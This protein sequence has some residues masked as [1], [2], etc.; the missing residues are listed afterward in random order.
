MEAATIVYNNKQEFGGVSMAARQVFSGAGKSARSAGR[1]AATFTLSLLASAIALAQQAPAG[2]EEVSVTGSRLRNDSFTAPTPVMTL[3][4][5]QLAAVAPVNIAEALQQLPQFSTGGQ[6]STAVVYANLR[7]IGSE[8]TLVLLNGRRHVPTFSSGV[9][10]LTT[11]PTALVARTEMVTGGASASWGSDAV[12]GVLN[13]IVNED[14]EGFQGNAQY[15]ES[16][17]GDD[18]SYS[19]SLAW[20]TDFAGG[21]GHII[22]GV[23]QAESKGIATY[24]YPDVS[25]PNVAGRSSV[26][27]G[28]YTTGLPQFIYAEDVRRSDVHDGGLITSGPLRGTIFLPGGQTGQFQYGTN[29]NN[30]MIG[31]GSN[32]YETP[33]P[34]GDIAPPYERKSF[35]THAKYD[36]SETLSGFLEYNYSESL[37]NGRSVMPRNQGATTANTGC[38]RTSYSGSFFG[39]INVSSDNAFLPQAVR[40]QMAAARINCFNFGRTY[41]E[42]GLGLFRTG[43]GSPEIHRYVAGLE[44]EIGGGWSWDT[45]VQYGDSSFQ[46]RREGNIHS[47]RFQAAIDAV[48][49]PATGSTVC[50]I[51]IDTNPNN[52]DPACAPFNLFGAGS[53]SDAAK[54]YVVGTS[55]LD[56]D[57]EQTVAA[58]N[59]RGDLF[60]GWAGPISSAFGVEYREESLNAVADP[61]SEAGRWQTSNRKALKGSYD[62]KEVYAE[63]GVP[64]LSGAPLADSVDLSLAARST[65]YSSS[66][67]VTTWK[68]GLTWD[69]NE[70]L[71]FRVTKS[72]DIRAGNLGELF[73]PTAVALGNINNPRTS[74]RVPVQTITTG[75]PVLAPEEADT[76]TAGVVLAPA[77]IEGLQL[78]LDYYSIDIDG[79]I[80]TVSAQQI[81]DQCYLFNEQDFCARVT[82]DG[83]GLITAINNSFFNLDR[84]K[85]SGVDAVAAYS[86]DIGPG[87]MSFR[88][89]SAY[90]DERETTF[91]VAGTVQDTA[92]QVG[93]PHWKHFTQVGYRVG[94]FSGLIDWRWY[95]GG[96]IS[97]LRIEGFAGVQGANVNEIPNLHYTSLSLNY[98]FSGLL[99]G[100]NGTVFGRIDNLFDRD[101]PFPLRNA[102]NDNN[103]RGYRVGVRFNM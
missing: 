46:Q 17:Y 96:K 20:G 28:N 58:V 100:W 64:L 76:F 98:D 34:G 19:T 2:I 27:N 26:S 72:K 88:L 4:T 74:I 45:Y 77:A 21:R 81:V 71:R 8:R 22:A 68:T 52:N 67:E 97:N 9:V 102:Y 24:L 79:Q 93:T 41:R 66:G 16:K 103:G 80:G 47:V 10:D 38:T 13:L 78:S 30:N 83:N 18:E 5:E 51:N 60:E 65:D 49:D 87:E 29:Y 84:F 82:V 44:G 59:L 85:T 53:P 25:R 23:E 15:G 11:I 37:S 95:Q 3:S 89:S 70:Q 99:G 57:I 31:G 86:A 33:D 61:D 39:N 73:T 69:V 42:E 7:N 6:S 91:Q 32:P 75:N 90:V 63:L 48:R 14:L 94:N 62:V 35:L 54:R 55:A 12:S 36:L 40:D 92:G 1:V 101:P 56:M 43:E 50:R